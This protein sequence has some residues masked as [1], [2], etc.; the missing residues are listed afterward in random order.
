MN[1]CE[2]RKRGLP[3]SDVYK[4]DQMCYVNEIGRKVAAARLLS[5]GYAILLNTSIIK[6][7]K[8][9]LQIDFYTWFFYNEYII[10][11]TRIQVCFEHYLK[12]LFLLKGFVVKFKKSGKQRAENLQDPNTKLVLIADLRSNFEFTYMPNKQYNEIAEL[13]RKTI[14]FDH[15]IKRT[16]IQLM[17]QDVVNVLLQYKEIRNILHYTE[18]QPELF[19]PTDIKVLMSYADKSIPPIVN[20]LAEQLQ[21]PNL[22]IEVSEEWYLDE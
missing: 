14:S 21:R 15:L 8:E 13:S 4:R 20:H 5:S 3:G 10:D 16:T 7:Y 12:A 22:R 11:L 2:A 18:D 19:D 6:H 9:Q 1:D 17:P